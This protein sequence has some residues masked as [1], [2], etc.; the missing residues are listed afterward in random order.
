MPPLP[1]LMPISETPEQTR[2]AVEYWHHWV[3]MGYEFG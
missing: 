3:G 1:Q 2:E